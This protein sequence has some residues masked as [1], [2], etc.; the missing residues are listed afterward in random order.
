MKAERVA[1]RAL[2]ALSLV[3]IS[4]GE[5]PAQP[6]PA[7]PPP[8]LVPTTV[9]VTP[10]TVEFVA[11]GETAQFAAEVRDQ[12]GNA[13]AGVSV[14]WSSSNTSVVT[15][16]SSGLATAIGNGT[17]TVTAAAAAATGSASVTMTQQPASISIVP[18]A[19][20]LIVGGS[21]ALA[22][23]AEDANGHPVADVAFTWVS[24]DTA[25][26]TV[27]GS[28]MA[29]ATGLGTV[30]V[31]AASGT[32]ESAARIAVVVPE[33]VR[34]VDIV[35]HPANGGIARGGGSWELSL[36]EVFTQALT[37]I[38]NPGYDFERW[39]EDGV[40]ISTDPAYAMQLAGEHQ[41]SAH[42]SVNQ[43]RGRWGPG[44]THTDWWFPDTAY[45]SFAWTFLPAVDP[46]ASLTTKGL[47][48]YYAFVFWL[49]GSTPQ[50]G[51]GYAGFQ[52]NGRFAASNQGKVVNFSIW[53]SDASVTPRGMV[54]PRNPE[55]RCHQ[56][57]LKYEYEIGRAYRFELR[58]GPSGVEEQGKW[59]GLWVADLAAD[60]VTFVG[61]M[62][63]PTGSDGNP[64]AMLKPQAHVFGEDLYW[65]RSRHGGEQYVCSDFE[66][67]SLAVLDV[68]AGAEGHRAWNVS[69]YTTDGRLDVAENGYETT[70]CHVTVFAAENGD[71]QH[72]V[73][74]WPDPPERVIGR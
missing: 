17:A 71:V 21:V 27:D 55:C 59:W 28:G 13:M 29:G 67:S 57:M 61:E 16:D 25:V 63:V 11:I 3:L 36:Q 30:D 2:L 19:F 7:P 18:T 35:P 43:E 65:W 31:I 51:F 6:P 32:A 47:L 64:G 73:G 46:P 8:A 70:L 23:S 69:P 20:R 66:P 60:S 22:A 37:A 44:N 14:T 48:H 68:V 56:I 40:T 15:L 58:E 33:Q 52:S 45:T 53:G 54:D 50:L 4:C 34:S 12:F 26:A 38:P 49:Q 39:A 42:F 24:G 9:V 5:D 62:R 41:L 1:R 72:N 10:S 74:F